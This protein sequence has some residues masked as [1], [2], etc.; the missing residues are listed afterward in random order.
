M[1]STPFDDGKILGRRLR[2]T[3]LI[4]SPVLLTQGPAPQT[5]LH[6]RG[7][8]AIGHLT[9]AL[10]HGYKTQPRRNQTSTVP[11]PLTAAPLM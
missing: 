3:Y 6:Q 2:S 11:S 9:V 1:D 10:A 4:H 7:L 5:L 8:L